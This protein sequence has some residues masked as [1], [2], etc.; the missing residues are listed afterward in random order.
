MGRTVKL[1]KNVILDFYK[2]NKL[3]GIEIL[4][5]SKTVPETKTFQKIAA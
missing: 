3:I 1:D 5:A 2:K 4:N